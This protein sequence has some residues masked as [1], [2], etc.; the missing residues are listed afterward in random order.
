MLLQYAVLG[1][2]TAQQHTVWHRT[3]HKWALLTSQ[4]ELLPVGSYHSA[5]SWFSLSFYISRYG[6][7]CRC[8]VNRSSLQVWH[9]LATGP[10]SQ[11]S[12]TLAFSQRY[13]VCLPSTLAQSYGL[14][15]QTVPERLL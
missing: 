9:M 13:K 4:C 5:E 2:G 11:E 3:W 15:L 1:I 6:S 12:Y 8:K 10:Q 14:G 7:G